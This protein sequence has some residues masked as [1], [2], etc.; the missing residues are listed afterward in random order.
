MLQ[1]PV[2]YSALFH[3]G[4]RFIFIF[5]FFFSSGCGISA[6]NGDFDSKCWIETYK[7]KR[8][9]LFNTGLSADFQAF[10]KVGN[11]FWQLYLNTSL[12]FSLEE[13]SDLTLG[14]ISPHRCCSVSLPANSGSAWCLPN[15]L[16]VGCHN[17]VRQR[18]ELWWCSGWARW[19]GGGRTES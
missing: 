5:F 16:V 8:H 4:P 1:Q 12:S 6:G 2:F 19:S 13:G 3:P 17:N 7:A 14:L 10:H 9:L 11:H 15:P 18:R